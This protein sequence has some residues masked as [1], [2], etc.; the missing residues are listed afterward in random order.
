MENTESN[1]ENNA[2]A[3]YQGVWIVPNS[4]EEDG[5]EDV[6]EREDKGRTEYDENIPL[7]FG[8]GGGNL[9][10]KLVHLLGKLKWLRFETK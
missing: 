9:T 5:G 4:F 1:P 8:I 3:M 2:G 6:D 10:R 7:E